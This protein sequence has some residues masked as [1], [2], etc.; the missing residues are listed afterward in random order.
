[1]AK[2]IQTVRVK[3]R[4]CKHKYILP[5]DDPIFPKFRHLKCPKCKRSGAIY[6][7]VS[8]SRI[9]EDGAWIVTPFF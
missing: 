3:C 8:T 5:V 6:G 7:Y 4:G 2:I 9:W 1:M